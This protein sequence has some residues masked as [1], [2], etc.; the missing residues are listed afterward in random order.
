MEKKRKKKGGSNWEKNGENEKKIN[1]PFDDKKVCPVTNQ[2]DNR[3]PREI[4]AIF[5]YNILKRKA[6]NSI[7]S[8]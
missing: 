5:V 7:F 8:Y 3:P 1:C 4:G 6:F 2:I